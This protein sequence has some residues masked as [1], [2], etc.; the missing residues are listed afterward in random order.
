MRGSPMDGNSRD[1]PGADAV[2]VIRP[3]FDELMAEVGLSKFA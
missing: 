3:K 2:A 1:P